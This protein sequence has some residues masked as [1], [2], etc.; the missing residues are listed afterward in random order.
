MPLLPVRSAGYLPAALR[1]RLR[2][3]GHAAVV[4][5]ARAQVA[6]V[7]NG[8]P[9]TVYDIEQRT[10]LMQI[11]GS[12]KVPASEQAID[13]LIADKLKLSAAKG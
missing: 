12:Q 1:D 4:S 3:A 6:I 7:V 8:D 11:A 5:P 2:H 13:E 9:I 10:K